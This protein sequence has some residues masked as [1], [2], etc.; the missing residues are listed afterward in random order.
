METV[1]LGVAFVVERGDDAGVQERQ[2]AQTLR[3]D[4]VAV[5]D[6]LEDLLVG[7]ERDLGAATFGGDLVSGVT[8][9]PRSNA[10][11]HFARRQITEVEPADNAFTTDTTC[12]PAGHL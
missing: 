5:I 6:G 2:L 9:F 8:G 11:W 4:V 3:Q 1:G 7:L 12:R 10:C